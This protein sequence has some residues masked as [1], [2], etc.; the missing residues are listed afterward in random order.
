MTWATPEARDEVAAMLREGKSASQIAAHFR[1]VSRNA[2]IG[3][4]HRDKRLREIGFQNRA[5]GAG[6]SHV[7]G[8]KP[9]VEPLDTASDMRWRLPHTAGIPLTMFNGRRCKWCINAPEPRSNT[10]L[11]C[12]EATN[13]GSYCAHHAT[14]AVGEG[15]RSEQR[16]AETLRKAA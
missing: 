14:A 12:G 3:V 2:V 8:Q 15:T 7:P 10:H 1:G 16:A 5:G 6:G 13:G 11:F 9:V 4:V